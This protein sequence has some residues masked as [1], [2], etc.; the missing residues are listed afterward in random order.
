MLAKRKIAFFVAEISISLLQM[1]R[2][3]IVQAVLDSTLAQ[4]LAERFAIFH[5]DYIKVVDM[6]RVGHLPRRG[7][8]AAREQLVV[9]LCQDTTIVIPTVKMWQLHGEYTTLNAFQTQ[10]IGGEIVLVLLDRAVVP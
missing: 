9:T 2:N 3:R 7:N 10:V 6:L 8:L 4:G 5:Y 1:Q